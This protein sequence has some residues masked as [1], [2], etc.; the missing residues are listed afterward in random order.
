MASQSAWQM[1]VSQSPISG[2][3][4]AQSHL[5]RRLIGGTLRRSHH[6]HDRRAVDRIGFRCQSRLGKE[7][8]LRN[9]R[10]KLPFLA[11]RSCRS[12]RKG[13]ALKSRA[14]ALHSDTGRCTLSVGRKVKV[15]I[16]I[17]RT[18]RQTPRRFQ[19]TRFESDSLRLGMNSE[20]LKE[21]NYHVRRE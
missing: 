20:F 8:C 13:S 4:L 3:L 10:K 21:E 2:L 19:A 16:P 7:K 18:S 6:Q 15:D 11:L 5:T 17:C 12:H 9:E 14:I 1:C